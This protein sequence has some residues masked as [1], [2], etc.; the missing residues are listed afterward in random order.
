MMAN[1][2]QTRPLSAAPPGGGVGSRLGGGGHMDETAGF[3]PSRFLKLD[4]EW[5]FFFLGSSIIPASEMTPPA[6]VCFF[7]E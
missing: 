1:Y 6:E 5:Y 7:L 2:P 4:C 3:A